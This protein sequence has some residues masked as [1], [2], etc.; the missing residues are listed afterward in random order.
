MKRSSLSRRDFF[1][2]SALGAGAAV[3]V[4]AATAGN[5]CQDG[6]SQEEGPADF[7]HVRLN[8]TDPDRTRRFYQRMFG[9]LPVKFRGV[10]D[11]LFTGHSFMLL[12]KVETAPP[13]ELRSSIWHIGWGGVDVEN[14]YEWW[15]ARGMDLHTEIYPLGGGFVTYWNG[16][17]KEVIELNTQ[18]H[19]R[20]SHVHLLA[21]DINETARWYTENLGL[22]V[23][24]HRPKPEDMNSVRA[25]S[26]SFRCGF[27]T[28]NIYGKPD[29]T[30]SP[31]WW[32]WEPLMEFESQMGRAVDHLAFS[33]R[34]I[35]PVFDR[36]RRDGVE[37]V[38]RISENAEH[39]IKSFFVQAPDNVVV[40]IVEARPIPEGLWD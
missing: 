38:A 20:Y 26:T 23:P 33:F 17:D 32:R 15:K 11:A 4:D 9:A 14:E 37:I 28:I 16:P 36:M 8:V 1:K 10:S 3:S 13:S 30:P 22:P 5:S 18:G 24:R 35:E 2:H 31:V 6:D 34:N 29:Y 19:H 21:N 40:E 7:H 39:G 27:V 12:N 25:W